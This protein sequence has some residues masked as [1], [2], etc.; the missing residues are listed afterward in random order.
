VIRALSIALLFA[1][2]AAAQDPDPDDQMIEGLT[3]C[4]MIGSDAEMAAANLGLYG[5]S[6]EPAE[7]GLTIALPGAG[8]DTFVLIDND[9]SFC[10]VESLTL[11]TARTAELLDLALEGA[12][13]SV[14]AEE[15]DET[16]CA[17]RSLTGGITVT[18]TAG[19]TG[20]T[21]TADATAAVRFAFGAVQ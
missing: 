15:T 4:A 14:L 2:P 11:G 12:G 18:L 5:W 1:A 13:I 7:G 20:T 21:C 19:G 16:G 6:H 10:L 8:G 9:G 3:V 17:R